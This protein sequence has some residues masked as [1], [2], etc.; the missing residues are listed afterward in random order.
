MEAAI[1]MNTNT[2]KIPT[3]KILLWLGMVSIVMLF[4][5]LTSAYYVKRADGNWF[6]FDLPFNIFYVST[7]IILLSSLTMQLAVSAVKKNNLQAVKTYLIIT[8]G[9][10]LA[11]VFSQF[12]GWSNLVDHKVFFVGN[13]SGS[14]L[15]VLTGLH[16]AHLA[17][18]IIG[19]MFTG[20]G[21]IRERYNSSNY[22]GISVCATYWH[23]LDALWIYL[24]VFLAVFR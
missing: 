19:L 17:G 16:L 13:P 7:A 6:E 18:G 15:F 4:A 14:F 8:L 10:G 11:F 24:F 2:N 5:G 22:V 20:A 12:L 3:Q 23:F 1:N 21:A 9:L